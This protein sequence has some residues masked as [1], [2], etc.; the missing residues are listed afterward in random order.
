METI[1]RIGGVLVLDS[2]V[3]TV[4]TDLDVLEQRAPGLVRGEAELGRER[5]TANRQ[6]PSLEEIDRL[7]AG[8]EQT[9]G[10]GLDVKVDERS[11]I[12]MCPD[13]RG[14]DTRDVQRHHR[15]SRRRPP[16]AS[17]VCR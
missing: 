1:E 17:R 10:L 15:A 2:E 12:P 11:V 5:R 7:G 14:G 16:Q 9:V 13:E 6:Q 3:A 4:E 8:L